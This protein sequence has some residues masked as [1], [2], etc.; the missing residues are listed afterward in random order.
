[1]A[2]TGSTEVG[3]IIMKAAADSNLKRVSLELGG[4]SP[5]VRFETWFPEVKGLTPTL[6]GRGQLKV[7]IFLGRCLIYK[8]LLRGNKAWV[9]LLNDYKKVTQR[10]TRSWILCNEINFENIIYTSFND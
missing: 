10:G 1:M 2:F 3:K 6:V 7:V 9:R 5:L 4:K 8:V